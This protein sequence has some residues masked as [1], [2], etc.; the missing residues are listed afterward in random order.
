MKKIFWIS[1][2]VL[3]VIIILWKGK[4]IVSF[5]KE[6]LRVDGSTCYNENGKKGEWQ[7]GLCSAYRT[8]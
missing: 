8:I 1:I 6:K 2:I 5:T 3:V 7:D 4:Q